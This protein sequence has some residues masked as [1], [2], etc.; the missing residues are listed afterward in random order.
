MTNTFHRNDATFSQV[1]YADLATA[2]S[3]STMIYTGS[4]GVTLVSQDFEIDTNNSGGIGAYA[5]C[6]V[7][8]AGTTVANGATTAGSNLTFAG[9]GAAGTAVTLGTTPAGTWRNVSGGKLND[10]SSPAAT[11]LWIRTA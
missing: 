4:K 8:V 5:L 3:T 10:T 9:F 7:S 1:A 2:P 11:G 6:F